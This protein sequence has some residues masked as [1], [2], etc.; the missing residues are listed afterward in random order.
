VARIRASVLNM[1][2]TMLGFRSIFIKPEAE[3]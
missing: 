1:C 3:S 2:R